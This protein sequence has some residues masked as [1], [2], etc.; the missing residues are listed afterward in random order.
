MSSIIESMQDVMLVCRRGHVITDLLR[1]CPERSL[2]HCDRCG[3]VTLERCPTCG[4]ELPGALVVPGLQPIGARQ[5]PAYCA[6]CGAAF[7]W[8]KQHRPPKTEALAVLENMLGRLPRVIRQLRVRHGDRPPFRVVD[9]KD[10]EDLLRSLL[11]LHFDDIRP[12]CRT[13]SYAADTRTDFLLAP[14]RI[15]VTVKFP[16]SWIIEQLREDAAYYRQERKCRTLVAFVY[17]PEGVIHEPQHLQAACSELGD[18][19]E[20]RC[21]VGLL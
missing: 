4:R 6:T 14:E 1:S 15:A 19:F 8:T 13:P 20:V 3:A 21:V 18:E 7:P 2:M 16:P 5:P 17:D 10:L 9:E 12:E 11:P